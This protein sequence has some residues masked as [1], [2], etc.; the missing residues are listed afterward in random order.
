[1]VIFS[2][3]Y[4][5]ENIIVKSVV[6]LGVVTGRRGRFTFLWERS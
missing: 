4:R 6:F 3:F 5:V 1:M 2:I